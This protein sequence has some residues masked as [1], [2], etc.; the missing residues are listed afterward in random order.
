MIGKLFT[1]GIDPF[2]LIDRWLV[3]CDRAIE[4]LDSI[5]NQIAIEV[6]G[7][8]SW[9]MLSARLCRHQA[10]EYYCACRAA[11]RYYAWQNPANYSISETLEKE[12][13]ALMENVVAATGKQREDMLDLPTSSI[14]FSRSMRSMQRYDTLEPW[15]ANQFYFRTMDQLELKRKIKEKGKC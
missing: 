6:Q 1:T 10:E 2:I 14:D 9:I 5:K 12:M 13:L 4:L 8:L 15:R 3:N 11:M 7:E